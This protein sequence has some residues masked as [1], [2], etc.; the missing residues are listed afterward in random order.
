[1][2]G[3]AVMASLS[4][5]GS[6]AAIVVG[7]DQVR[8][9]FVERLATTATGGGSAVAEPTV[10]EKYAVPSGPAETHGAEAKSAVPPVQ[11]VSPGIRLR[12]QDL[13]PSDEKPMRSLRAP[14][15]KSCCQV[16]INVRGCAGSAVIA[17]SISPPVTFS[18]SCR[19][20]GQ[21]LGN[22]VGPLST[23][24][25]FTWRCSP[26]CWLFS[27]VCMGAAAAA[28]APALASRRAEVNVT[29]LAV[30]PCFPRIA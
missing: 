8:P 22:G 1:M 12:R 23:C 29:T 27:L 28:A 30:Y 6:G 10:P 7:R 19:A 26:R 15:P 21:P 2:L 4:L 11:M 17:G 14:N 25:S 18:S 13:P 24:L 20:P 16:P 5:P 9:P 3:L